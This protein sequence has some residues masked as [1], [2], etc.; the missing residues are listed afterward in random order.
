MQKFVQKSKYFHFYIT[1]HILITILCHYLQE[2]KYHNSDIHGRN[3]SYGSDFHQ[4]ISNLTLYQRGSYHMGLKVF[5]SLPTYIKDI[6]CNVKEFKS[7][8]KNFL[9]SKSFYMP[10]EYFQ[11]N[12]T[13]YINNSIYS[14][15]LLDQTIF[16]V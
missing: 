5:N 6:H 12:N 14:I 3:T 16:K 7:L 10:E 4:T 15:V 1:I 8:L 13:Q 9:F 2:A 11:Y